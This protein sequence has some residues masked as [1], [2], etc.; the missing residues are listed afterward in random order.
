MVYNKA[1]IPFNNS[2]M[3]T[4]RV[5][6]GKGKDLYGAYSENAPGIWGEGETVDET[7]Q[8]FMKA[9]E[10]FV[11]YNELHNIPEVLKGEYSL[12]WEFE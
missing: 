2:D 1:W 10:L 3:K 5:T 12:E 6:I 8:S 7:K 9:I 4:L 11:E